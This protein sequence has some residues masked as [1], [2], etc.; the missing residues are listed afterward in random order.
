MTREEMTVGKRAGLKKIMEWYLDRKT[1]PVGMNFSDY[2]FVCDLY[3]N[4]VSFY[5][6]DIKDRLNKLR[7]TYLKYKD[8]D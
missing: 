8:Y 3:N 7:N 5:G 2:E 1:I 4:G 6:T